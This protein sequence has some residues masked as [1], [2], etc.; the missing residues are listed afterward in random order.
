MHFLNT[1]NCAKTSKDECDRFD[2]YALE[3]RPWEAMETKDTRKDRRRKEKTHKQHSTVKRYSHQGVESIYAGDSWKT[4]AACAAMGAGA[5]TVGVTGGL[6]GG[7]IMLGGSSAAASA[8]A[9]A[10]IAGAAAGAHCAVRGDSVGAV[11]RKAGSLAVEGA[12]KAGTLASEGAGKAGN[13][14]NGAKHFSVSSAVSVAACG[15]SVTDRL[16]NRISEVTTA[17]GDATGKAKASLFTTASHVSNTVTSLVEAA[18]ASSRMA[19][20][21]GDQKWTLAHGRSEQRVRRSTSLAGTVRRY[22]L[23][24]PDKEQRRAGYLEESF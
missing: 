16:V 24:P 10:S 15:K 12:E 22:K 9:L 23:Q 8:G 7:L 17:V 13:L 6:A 4:V 20:E 21:C 2:G 3:E 5:L 11:A 19:D 14:A 18:P 1:E